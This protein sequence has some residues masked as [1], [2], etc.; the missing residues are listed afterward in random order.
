MNLYST[1]FLNIF[2][3]LEIYFLLS[4]LSLGLIS[5]IFL[6]LS[7]IS[8]CSALYCV[9]LKRH[10][11][12]V[13]SRFIHNILALTTFVTGMIS[14]IIAYN[15]KTWAKKHDPGNMRVLMMWFLA[16]IIILTL[17]GPIKTL[18]NH[19]KTIVSR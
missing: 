1:R 2:I 4:H 11:K 18:W 17:I 3:D 13:Y 15:T 10:L 14:V 16:F 19:L 7:I 5:F 12:P 6:I 9:E 8:G